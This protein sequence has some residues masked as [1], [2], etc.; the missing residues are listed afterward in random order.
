MSRKMLIDATHSEETRVAVIEDGR[1][2]DFDYESQMRKQLKS[3]IFL[4]KVTRVEPSLQAAFVDFGGNRHGFLPFSEIHPDY[5][6]I[7]IADREAILEEQKAD[8][9][10]RQAAAEA[11]E[12]AAKS[13]GNDDDEDEDGDDDDIVDEV[14]GDLVVAVDEDDEEEK[15]KSKG[16]RK[17]SK[18]K[19]SKKKGE[20]SD[21]E[22][23][24]AD[25][26][27]SDDADAKTP[28]KKKGAKA[29]KAE[30]KDAAE[31]EASDEGAEDK[32][33]EK[34]AAKGK[35][36]RGRRSAY[37]SRKVE[38]VG[39]D[40]VESERPTRPSLRRNYKIQEVIKRGQIM[41]IQISREERGNKGAAVTTYISLPGR[42]CVLMPN[43][44]R[45]GGVSRKIENYSDRRRMKDILS[46]LKV[47][48]GMSVI[49]RTAGVERTKAEI[50]RD[51]DYLMR[52]WDKTRELTL[53]STVPALI[54]EEGNLIRR[55]IRDIYT[56]DIEEVIVAGEGGY[57]MARDFMKI[58]IPSHSK[59]VKSYEDE[60]VP[61]FH[62]Y[63][64]ESQINEIGDTNVTLKSGGYLVINPTEAL[65]SVD[66]NSGKATRARNIE[67]TALQ[68]NLEAAEE[69]ARQLKLRDLG[70]LVVIDFIDMEDRR[71]NRKVENCIKKALSADRA[72]IQI[73][74]ISSF[75]LMELSRQR[76]N[77]SLTEA[78]YEA[79]P[80]CNGVGSVRSVDSAAIMALRA[81]EEEGSKGRTGNISL[82]ISNSIAIYI[83]NN[84]RAMLDEI[85]RKYKF[86]VLIRVDDTVPPRGYR[87]DNA[88]GGPS[89]QSSH[90]SEKS[91]GDKD[92]AGGERRGG[93]RRGRRGGR[94]QSSRRNN[95]RHFNE[96]DNKQ[97]GSSSDKSSEE[98]SQDINK[99]TED[100]GD[101]KKSDAKPEV[102][103]TKKGKR[104]STAKGSGKSPKKPAAKQV[105]KDEKGS[106]K[107]SASN[108][109]ESGKEEKT[110]PKKKSGAKK[111]NENASSSAKKDKSAAPEDNNEDKGG[112]N[113]EPSNDVTP[114]KN[115]NDYEV[116][117]EVPAKKKRGWWSKANE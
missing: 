74:R 81:L 103:D 22:V 91:Y 31:E 37:K 45:S 77:P 84:K 114:V 109:D 56:R 44:P 113:V 20:E 17:S 2:V 92:G 94:N 3:N 65:V 11:E 41:L 1:L 101:A 72:R 82:V 4:A 9:E 43:S 59:R 36:R 70:G 110:T 60:K 49:M 107:S 47:P 61:L 88:K 69:V 64:I 13:A 26:V 29:G 95:N 19:S 112:D 48:D 7:P 18:A 6:R 90:H 12:E 96:S 116:V 16:K 55:S 42:Y 87:I 105:D 78:Q 68:T 52:M 71:N 23:A 89:R 58:M 86:E 108:V 25:E 80:H 62:K 50:K 76:L 53:E 10:A 21:D 34:G 79:C 63:Q 75:G 117:N 5:F 57:K 32:Q 39:G 35:P 115:S 93:R 83:L 111:K 38:I 102:K 85:E 67:S 104:K 66:V 98:A 46:E 14:G 27:A 73:G 24:E 99:G 100:A 28:A 33:S 97:D 8:M 54:H 15:S 40:G 30:D 106:S 51:A